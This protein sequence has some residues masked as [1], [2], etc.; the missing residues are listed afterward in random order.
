M[1]NKLRQQISLQR[2]LQTAASS[3]ILLVRNKVFTRFSHSALFIS[4]RLSF[5]TVFYGLCLYGAVGKY[6]MSRLII[7]QS[8]ERSH[9]SCVVLAA[10][11]AS[12]KLHQRRWKTVISLAVTLEW[13][14]PR[15][16][17]AAHHMSGFSVGSAGLEL[18]RRPGG[19]GCGVSCWV[20][21]IFIMQL[22]SGHL[23]IDRLAEE[24]SLCVCWI[25]RFIG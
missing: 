12:K 19:F 23:S 4:S 17:A 22:L 6:T 10:A 25:L 20:A 24:T 13:R 8:V 18:W 16:S 15:H 5:C 7:S 3:W 2:K 9:F 21:D 14:S 11:A 1:T